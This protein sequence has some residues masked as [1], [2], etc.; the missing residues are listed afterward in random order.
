MRL[1]CI[2]RIFFFKWCTLFHW[3]W[4]LLK[5][6]CTHLGHFQIEMCLLFPA[7]DAC[8]VIRLQSTQYLLPL[9]S[10]LDTGQNLS[11]KSSLVQM[12]W[13][14]RLFN[15][16]W[17]MQLIFPCLNVSIFVGQSWHYSFLK[18]KRQNKPN[19]C[20]FVTCLGQHNPQF[21]TLCYNKYTACL[22]N[23]FS[24]WKVS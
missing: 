24:S 4:T 12:G 19:E 17:P 15:D 1:C 14:P 7:L 6:Y 11:D 20:E 16:L 21:K 18:A 8:T 22:V 13:W 9:V 5:N 2:C 3:P 23:G 10:I